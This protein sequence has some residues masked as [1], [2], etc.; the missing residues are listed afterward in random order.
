M[1]IWFLLMIRINN[2][3]VSDFHILFLDIA[4]SLNSCNKCRLFSNEKPPKV[5]FW[6]KN[7]KG[8]GMGGTLKKSIF[9]VG[10][11][12]LNQIWFSRLSISLRMTC[13]YGKYNRFYD[14]IVTFQPIILF[15][16]WPVCIWKRT[17]LRSIRREDF[18]IFVFSSLPTND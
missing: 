7:F 13:W 14:I 1:Q 17:I 3:H 6:K 4:I 9:L 10:N 5:Q 15:L 16:C 11:V 2:F 8:K 12:L 18:K